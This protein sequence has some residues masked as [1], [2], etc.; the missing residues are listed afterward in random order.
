MS[1]CDCQ[2]TLTGTARG[3]D[4]VSHGLHAQGRY[5]VRLVTGTGYT[6]NREIQ[7]DVGGDVC[8]CGLDVVYTDG[9]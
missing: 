7:S 1:L 6:A 2:L 5:L 8:V 4:E 3:L 9:R